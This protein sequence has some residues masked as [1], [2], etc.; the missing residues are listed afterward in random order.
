MNL[1]DVKNLFVVVGTAGVCSV[2][3]HESHQCTCKPET[4]TFGL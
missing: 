1:F 4:K 2:A 3:H